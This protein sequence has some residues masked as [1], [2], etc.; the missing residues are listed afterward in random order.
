MQSLLARWSWGILFARRHHGTNYTQ[1]HI[2]FLLVDKW[3]WNHLLGYFLVFVNNIYLL[4]LI[5]RNPHRSFLSFLEDIQIMWQ[6]YK[7]LHGT[8]KLIF[9]LA[10]QS[11]KIIL[12]QT[13]EHLSSHRVQCVADMTRLAFNSC[14]NKIF[15]I[16]NILS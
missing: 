13:L 12:A 5:Q 16:C 14:F 9:A 10:Q 2:D 8:K 3:R 15:F 7:A 4:K 1:K 6:V 11:S